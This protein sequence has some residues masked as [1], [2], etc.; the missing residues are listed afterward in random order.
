M[1]R[2]REFCI[3]ERVKCRE[4]F[5]NNILYVDSALDLVQLTSSLLMP[6]KQACRGAFGRH[7][8]RINAAYRKQC[9]Q[10]GP[11]EASYGPVAGLSEASWGVLGA[12]WAPLRGLLGASWRLLRHRR[13]SGRHSEALRRGRWR[14]WRGVV[15]FAVSADGVL[16]PP[17]AA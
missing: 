9:M 14:S 7:F 1:A 16:A 12:S 15:K 8:V 2:C 5:L 17:Y 13:G 6:G 3:A 11:V 10:A 4:L